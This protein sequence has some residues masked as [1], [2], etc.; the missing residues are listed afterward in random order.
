MVRVRV[1]AMPSESGVTSSSSRSL[2]R[3]SRSPL[4][5]AAC[6]AAPG[7][8]E[9]GG[10]GEVEGEGE[11]EGEGDGEGEGE[12]EGEGGVEGEGEGDSAGWR[13]P[14]GEQLVQCARAHL[15]ARVRG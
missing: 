12:G 13:A 2:V 10:E 1:V 5:T 8:G 11:G 3:S 15:V 14:L 6:T 7:E 9:G 4:S